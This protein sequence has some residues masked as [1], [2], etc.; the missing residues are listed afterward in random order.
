MVTGALHAPVEALPM[1]MTAPDRIPGTPSTTTACPP[2]VTASLF[3]P[4]HVLAV[5]I[6]FAEPNPLDEFPVATSS[7][8]DMGLGFVICSQTTLAWLYPSNAMLGRPRLET[9]P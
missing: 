3:H 5:E 4:K 2:E 6:V 8:H 7:A 9:L 1:A